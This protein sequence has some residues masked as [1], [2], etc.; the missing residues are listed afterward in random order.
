[1]PRKPRLKVT[2]VTALLPH[3]I[4]LTKLRS[5]N[6]LDIQVRSGE[7]FLGTLKMGRGK[8]PMVA[9]QHSRPAHELAT[10]CRDADAQYGVS[11]ARCLYF[12]GTRLPAIHEESSF[13]VLRTSSS[14]LA[15]STSRSAHLPRSSV[16]I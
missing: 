6:T 11:R 5:N 12:A 8:R 7:E 2:K 13:S 14:G 1:M 9:Q 10:V 15:L 3:S 4:D 16:P